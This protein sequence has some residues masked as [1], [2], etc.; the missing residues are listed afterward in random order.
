MEF[1]PSER[2]RIV[3]IADPAGGLYLVGVEVD[4]KFFEVGT[5]PAYGTTTIDSVVDASFLDA[6]YSGMIFVDIKPGEKGNFLLIFQRLPWLSLTDEEYIQEINAFITTKKTIVANTGQDGSRSGGVSASITAAIVAGVVTTTAPHGLVAGD[7]VTFRSLSSPVNMAN[8]TRYFVVSVGTSSFTFSATQGGA[9]ITSASATA[10]SGTATAT[11][12]LI[13]T[14]YR[15]IDKARRVEIITRFPGGVI[16]RSWTFRAPLSYAIPA[17][18]QIKPVAKTV[19]PAYLDAIKTAYPLMTW[20]DF[21]V[22]DMALDYDIKQGYTKNFS[23]TVTRSLDLA[24]T[25]E[26]ELNMVP[27]GY[28]RIVIL[29]YLSGAGITPETLVNRLVPVHVPACIHPSWV[30]E[31][32]K[33]ITL[34][35]VGSGPDWT[36]VD[37]PTPINIYLPQTSPAEIPYGQPIVAK[38]ASSLWRGALYVNDIYRLVIPYPSPVISP[39]PQQFHPTPTPLSVTITARTGSTIRYT[40]NGTTPTKTNGTVLASGSSFTIS[41][42]KTIKA[43]CYNSLDESESQIASS[44]FE[45]I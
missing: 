17:E 3:E 39:D 24:S 33:K 36:V 41:S 29:Q 45:A 10:A 37:D 8:G 32:G 1:T 44:Y 25:T 16:G 13:V 9:A 20:L 23:A 26:T 30:I 43:I 40:D 4:P 31:V 19:R 7:P 18:I 21:V 34:E 6:R 28:S 27:E 5:A 38:V 11:T 2:P 14:E 15:D 22:S 35:L 42:S 12:D